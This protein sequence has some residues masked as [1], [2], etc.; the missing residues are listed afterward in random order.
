MWSIDWR[1]CEKWQTFKSSDYLVVAAIVLTRSANCCSQSLGEL[2]TE[3]GICFILMHTN[4]QKNIKILRLLMHQQIN[5]ELSTQPTP[6]KVSTIESRQRHSR[7][8]CMNLW[9]QWHVTHK[10]PLNT[11]SYL[12][13]CNNNGHLLTTMLNSKKPLIDRSWRLYEVRLISNT[14]LMDWQCPYTFTLRD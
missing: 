3:I 1:S 10:F 12:S 6:M 7:R 11:K 8:R 9:T 5:R 13:P 14:Q 4:V 2:L